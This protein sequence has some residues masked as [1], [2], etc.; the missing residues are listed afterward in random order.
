MTVEDSK[1]LDRTAQNLVIEVR[2]YNGSPPVYESVW[3]PVMAAK[4]DRIEIRGGAR[5]SVATIWFPMRRWNES[6]DVK[7]GDMIR[8][9]S[10]EQQ[11]ISSSV[12]FSGFITS[13]LSDFCGGS[14][15]TQAHERL[16]F[17]CMDARWVLKITSPLY[18]QIARGPDDYLS[19]GLPEQQPIEGEYTFLSGQRAIFNAGGK[20]NRDPA[21]LTVKSDSGQ[22]LCQAPI[23]ADPYNASLWSA[24][25]MVRYILSPLFNKA[26]DYVPIPDPNELNGLGHENWDVVLKHIVIEGL[27]IIDALDLIC[28]NLGWHFRLDYSL[29]GIDFVFYKIGGASAYTRT[30]EQPTILH[31]LYA[32]AAGENIKEAVNAGNKMLWAMQLAEDITTLVNN[33]FGLGAPHR[34]EFTAE[35]VPA[36]L[37][38]QLEPDTSDN[39]ANLFFTEA[40]LQDLTSPNDHTYYKYY[41]PRGAEFRRDVGRKWTLNET[42]KYSVSDT[43]DRGVP[44]DFTTIVPAE[45]ILAQDGRRLYAP[46]NRRLLPCLTVDKDGLNSVGIKLEFSFDEGDT[47]QVIPAA[48][49]CL[50]NECGIYID[51]ANLAEMVDEAEGTISGGTL[52][53]VQLNYFAS[54]C[55][56]KLNDRSFKD[57]DWKTRVR[58]TASVQLD[59]RLQKEI[60]PAAASG[61]PF[62]HAAIYDFSGDYYLNKRTPSSEFNG[63]LTAVEAD[64]TDAFDKH[65]Q[66]VREANQ[67]MSVSGQFTLDRLWLGDGAGQP[68]FAIGDCI[69]KIAG[70]DYNLTF[71]LGAG[72]TRPEIIQII[73]LPDKQMTKLITRDLR[74]TEVTGL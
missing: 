53:G 26:Y 68:D 44:F 69:E 12:V 7:W 63:S 18:G 2:R 25:D 72:N 5:P 13:Y 59:Q 20:P 28:R 51:E 36:W 61:S 4:V 6:F 70:R 15:K 31:Q 48:I 30:S 57:G 45:Y 10:N 11:Q 8:I 73:Y 52:D 58:V 40:D 38:S 71:N 19:Y 21:L 62:H 1:R 29:D 60:Q 14:D 43:Y 74:F 50:K 65:L 47:W 35:L 24:R 34:F 33:P 32:P 66:A 17:V 56:D 9:R 39:N 22:T 49:S 41:H 27:N 64:D 55:N 67:G 54:L 46:F 23:F 37:D 42:G 3:N 16:A